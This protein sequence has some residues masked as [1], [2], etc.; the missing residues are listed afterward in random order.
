MFNFRNITK[1]SMIKFF[2]KIRREF[3]NKGR[4]SKYF[5]YAIGEIVLLV[6]GVLIA[7]EINNWNESRKNKVLEHTY[8]D[9]IRTDLN[10][11]I[12]ELQEF[13]TSREKCITSS[14][15]ILDFF[16]QK[17]LLNHNDFNRHAID[18]M[19]WFPFQQHNNTYQELMNCGKLSLISNKT[20]KDY[21]QNMATRFKKMAF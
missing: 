16:E 12:S 9:N 11:N 20:I 19:V 3:I 14:S 10:L 17:R 1:L 8:L 7:L 2:R 18:V 6:L 21:L 5:K 15:V 4:I 13:I